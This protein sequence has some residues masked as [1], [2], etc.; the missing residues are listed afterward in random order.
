[1]TEPALGVLVLVN[2]VSD[3]VTSVARKVLF[4]FADV[5][6]PSTGWRASESLLSDVPTFPA[7][8]ET[9]PEMELCARPPVMT[10]VS[11][12]DPGLGARVSESLASFA[13][14]TECP[15]TV[16]P[17]LTEAPPLCTTSVAVLCVPKVAV[18][19]RA[20][21][22]ETEAEDVTGPVKELL[23]RVATAT[24][25]T[26]SVP[27]AYGHMMSQFPVLGLPKIRTK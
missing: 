15:S 17:S 24:P 3:V 2:R 21:G 22:A 4:I 14:M 6:D 27:P 10:D 8:A 11:E 12:T 20:A 1:M 26:R 5:T 7:N 9:R 25:F 13:K 16:S 19:K 23:P 18:P